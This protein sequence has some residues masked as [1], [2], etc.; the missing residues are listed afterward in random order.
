LNPNA[1]SREEHPGLFQMASNSD[2]DQILRSID[3]T[4]VLQPWSPVRSRGSLD[5]DFA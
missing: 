3:G 4:V 2:A 1:R 5:A